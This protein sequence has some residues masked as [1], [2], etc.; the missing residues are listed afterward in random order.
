MNP[1][2]RTFFG[3]LFLSYCLVPDLCAQSSTLEAEA[4]RGDGIY[5]LLRRYDLATAACNIEE[6]CRL[7]TLQLTD[8]LQ[9]G[10]AYQLPIKVYTYNG[11]S[12]RS[13]INDNDW[14]QAV[15][16]QSYNEAMLSAKR[17]ESDY[18]EDKIL[19]VPHHLVNC[20]A[21]KEEEVV[22]ETPPVL[23]RELTPVGEQN[24]IT[25]PRTFE[26][27]G[28]ELARV[29]LI[30]NKL[31]GKVY[32]LVAGHGGP[33]PGAIGRRSGN[34][35]CE[36]EY[37]YDVALRLCRQ[38]IAHGGVAYMVTRDPNDGIRD[39]Q[40]LP[41]DTDEVYWGGLA[42][43]RSQRLRLFQRSDIINGLYR[44]NLSS[45]RRDQTVIAIHVDSR[46]SNQRI[47]LFFYYHQDDPSG[48]ELAQKMQTVMGRQY[49]RFQPG[50]DYQGTVS[51]RD[52]HMLR[53]TQP[54]SV[55]IE[56]ANIKNPADQRRIVVERNRQLLAE[57]LCLGLLSE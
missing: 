46:N 8:Q 34:R 32:Y 55:Y 19:W 35:L 24:T 48:L 28:P 5:S 44:E 26:I 57:W 39:G 37:A 9:V 18:R 23:D 14:D 45:G 51:A 50:R 20:P 29:P 56:L 16:I 43:Q 36:D 53:E 52:L 40:Y 22:E 31:A 13:T 42:M 12:I 41:C 4:I 6:F 21:P 1:S 27:F 30:D 38:I 7:N 33:D 10:R 15:S 47:D 17:R 49:D 54:R 3:L 11:E 25:G 2:L